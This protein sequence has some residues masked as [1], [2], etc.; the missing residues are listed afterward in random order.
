MERV[1]AEAR[2]AQTAWAAKPLAE[3]LAV[4]RRARELFAERAKELADSLGERSGRALSETVM[5]EVITLTDACAFLEREAPALLAPRRLGSRGR[6]ALFM[7]VDTVIQREPLGVVLVIGPSNYPLFLP[8]SQALQA[9]AAGNACV[10]KPGLNSAA[11]ARLFA[12]YMADAGL[13]P[14]LLPVTDESPE[15]A[16]HALAAGVDKVVLTGSA[17]TGARV[18]GALAPALTPSTMELSGCDAVFV[19]AGADLDLAVRAL[20]WGLRL[21]AGATCIAPRRV[22]AEETIAGD[23]ERRF[24]EAAKSLQPMQAAAPAAEKARGLIAA[25]LKAGARLLLPT[26]IEEVGAAGAFKPVLLAG[27]RPEMEIAQ[28]DIF[29]PVISLMQVRGE[30]EAVAACERC[31]YALGAS[32]FGP[33]ARALLLA[34]RLHTGSV[35]INDL[36]APT[37]DPRVPFGGRGRSGFGVTRGAEGLLEMTAVKTV[38]VRSGTFRPHYDDPR[39]DDLALF[40]TYL[41]ATSGRTWFERVGAWCSVLKQLMRRK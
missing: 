40:Q 1:I 39:P 12:K 30:D 2:A 11:P 21:N 25:A 6:P 35:S 38:S 17:Q 16:Q 24:A 41:R 5:Y 26:A 28:A 14:R 27:V 4:L 34:A 37:A 22:F 20:R 8:C 33:E 15:A 9:L 36:I 32:I 31:P 13:D 19:L 3:R 23:F 10:I 7:G 18:L 29:A